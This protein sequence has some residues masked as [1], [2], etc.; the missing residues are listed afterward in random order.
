MKESH[1]SI[2]TITSR[3]KSIVFFLAMLCT[4]VL[5]AQTSIE[6]SPIVPKFAS[7]SSA[8]YQ[9]HRYRDGLSPF[10]HPFAKVPLTPVS[11]SIGRLSVEGVINDFDYEYPRTNG[12]SQ[13]FSIYSELMDCP[14]DPGMKLLHLGVSTSGEEP[15]SGKIVAEEVQVKIE[16]NPAYVESYR[17]VGFED[18]IENFARRKVDDKENADFKSGQSLTSLYIITPSLT[19]FE[20]TEEKLLYQSRSKD[21]I[22]NRELGIVRIHYKNVNG[23]KVWQT[24]HKI[25]AMTKYGLQISDRTHIAASIAEAELF[26]QKSPYCGS[27]DRKTVMAALAELPQQKQANYDDVV[28]NNAKEDAII[29]KLPPLASTLLLTAIEQLLVVDHP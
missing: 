17:I 23:R 10:R 25:A 16:F 28:A 1:T 3:L 6:I 19:G 15:E 24:K 26:D 7:I 2:G 11:K 27:R 8:E 21:L 12:R 29:R 22:E 5:S 20:S 9:V 18:P 14:W 13:P 4:D